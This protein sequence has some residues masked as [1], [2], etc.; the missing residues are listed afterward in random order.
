MGGPTGLYRH[1]G[2]EVTSISDNR[3]CE[4][5]S[6]GKIQ[7]IVEDTLGLLWL[8]TDSGI[9]LYDPEEERSMLVYQHEEGVLWMS[10][11]LSDNQG[12]IW[13]A[14][15]AALFK[16]SYS[17]KLKT[18]ITKDE[19]FKQ[20]ANNSFKIDSFP[21]PYQK[22][23]ASNP[24][25]SLNKDEQGNIWVGCAEGLFLM[26]KGQNTYIRLDRTTSGGMRQEIQFV[27]KILPIDENS[28]W[29]LDSKGLYLL[30]NIKMALQGNDPDV[31]LLDFSLKLTG[32]ESI[33]ILSVD[34]NKNFLV[35]VDKKIYLIKKANKSKEISFELIGYNTT[36]PNDKELRFRV[37]DIIEDRS[38]IIWIA[39]VSS[40]V[41]K[42]KMNRLVFTSYEKL[43]IQNLDS[44]RIC[45][46]YEDS[47][48]NLWILINYKA[49]Y[50]IKP[51][52]NEV[53]QY[54]PGATKKIT[55]FI[56]ASSN[57]LLWIGSDKGILEFNLKTGK[58]RDPL[59]HTGI[60][61]NL[62][63]VET[64][65]L[66]DDGKLLY[67]ATT[68]GLFAYNYENQ[69]IYKT[70][71]SSATMVGSL[72][73]KKN[74]EIWAVGNFYG[75][76]KIELN[77]KLDIL[78]LTPVINKNKFIDAEIGVSTNYIFYEDNNGFLWIGNE[79]GVHRLDP[80]T[81]ENQSYKLFE[82][83]DFQSVMSITSDNKNNL[84]LGTYK[85]LCRLNM[86]TGKLKVFEE[87]DGVPLIYYSRNSVFKDKEGR[88]FFG[89]YGG[90]YSF[91]PDS[92]KTND[93]VPPIIISD[94]R[95]FNKSVK[96]N[97]SK[98]DIL[99]RNIAYTKSINL[100][101]NQNDLSFELAALD[102]NQ[103]YKNKYAYKLE[104]YDKE[105]IF[106]DAKSRIATYTN[107]DPRTYVFRVKGS[108]NHDVWNEEG[109]SLTIQ[110][111]K[112]WWATFLAQSMYVLIVLCFVF[113]YI[114]LRLWRLKKEKLELE[115]QVNLRTRQIGEQKEEILSQRDM[116]EE[117]N[118]QISEHEELKSRF[119]ANVSHEFRTPLS[120]IQSPVEEL[121]DD[122]RRTEKERRKLNTVQ[123]NVR[124]L[125]NLV[126]QLL[127]ISKLDGS[128]MKL[129]LIEA[130]VI[131]HLQAITGIF[132]SLAETK[133]INYVCHFQKYETKYWFDPD[134]LEKITGNLLSNAFKFT[135]QGGE[136]IFT[137]I[138]KKSD[139]SLVEQFLEFS[140]KDTGPG[141]PAESLEKIFDRFYQVETSLKSESGGTGIG[142]SL[143]RD[144]V[145]LLHGDILVESTPGKGSSFTVITSP[146]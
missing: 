67:I 12:N 75:I 110:I 126:N 93:Y 82:N 11:M 57:G 44:I 56:P 121:L 29:I 145:K 32:G 109:I 47:L 107:L 13:A 40:G 3:G 63:K 124:R 73:K 62:R 28:A 84:W 100:K 137:A 27:R 39:Q 54:D 146:G 127:D 60:A 138:C 23:G 35:M 79:T 139:D 4:N 68:I 9:R 111:H 2:Y 77:T 48:K 112:P 119:F 16:I 7:K 14:D 104:G 43:T 81:G 61:D 20:G 45:K 118:R 34:G 80:N 105:W 91:Y 41:S 86:K 89:G 115:R 132:I 66:V 37:N 18:S 6:F 59:P 96:A 52:S 131:N 130:N 88:I 5:C 78:N 135:P 30:T 50:K 92:F 55:C 136:I 114:R 22:Q 106:T 99:T 10:T 97:T 140:V 141:I 85:K 1:N 83:T 87:D 122:P 94:L 90:F 142:L 65:D 53:T 129:E 19:I 21:P 17:E 42:F 117:Q 38:G 70:S 25:F 74:G 8:L 102:Y 72:I 128:K 26:K 144:I 36:Y 133:S 123:R 46:I 31:S 49:L 58:F 98:N 108:N 120:L 76:H 69:K 103:P 143:T 51:E 64:L 33:N 95:L 113:A 101:H 116:L 71:F 15:L 125:I 134:K 24:V